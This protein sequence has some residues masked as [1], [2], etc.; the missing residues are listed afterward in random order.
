MR[1]H[2]QAD[3]RVC[4]HCVLG[5]FGC[6]R[7]YDIWTFTVNPSSKIHCGGAG[8]AGA[9]RRAGEG[10]LYVVPGVLL[11]PNFGIVRVDGGGP[12]EE[13]SPFG[14]IK[15]FYFA[16][17]CTGPVSLG[18]LVVREPLGRLGRTLRSGY[19]RC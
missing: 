5:R 12:V 13:I 14:C 2:R 11:L 1:K 8:G 18:H 19:S 16:V 3:S 15:S 10:M 4:V 7:A 17:C 6:A 9:K